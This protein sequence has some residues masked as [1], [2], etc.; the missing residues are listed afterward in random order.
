ML[1]EDE[2]CDGAET[3]DE[4]VALA[5]G[6]DERGGMDDS[7]IVAADPFVAVPVTLGATDE[8]VNAGAGGESVELRLAVNW[9]L[10][11]E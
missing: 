2:F 1:L 4:E 8:L 7:V 3:G 10:S 5:D 11:L 6:S 9:A